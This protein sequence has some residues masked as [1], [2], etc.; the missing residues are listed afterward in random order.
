LGYS[1]ETAFFADSAFR[2]DC[3]CHRGVP[4]H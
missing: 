2:Q 4:L 1:G 3:V